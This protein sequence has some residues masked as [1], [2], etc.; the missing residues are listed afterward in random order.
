MSE[1]AAVK[2]DLPSLEV[3]FQEVKARLQM[4]F[5]A[6]GALDTKAS[7]ILGIGGLILV[8]SLSSS[9]GIGHGVCAWLKTGSQVLICA[10]AILSL[11]AYWV[12]TYRRDPEPRPL[13]QNYLMKAS[14]QTKK[15]ILDNWIESF[16]ENQGKINTKVKFLKFSFVF[17]TL[18]IV[19]MAAANC[20]PLV[21]R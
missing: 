5:A 4:Q 11:S 17:L 7:I 21:S 1:D 20:I 2:A 19:M 12:V 3:V 9:H 8:S 13:A 14:S 15:Q 16:E 10:A 6:I 18:G